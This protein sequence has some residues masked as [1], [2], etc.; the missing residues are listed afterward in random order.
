MAPGL[1]TDG[2]L[3]GITSTIVQ[4]NGGIL[5]EL[6]VDPTNDPMDLVN[7]WVSSYSLNCSVMHDKDGMTRPALATGNQDRE[8][9]FIVDLSTME[10]VW[11]EHGSHAS[12]SP[13][14]SYAAVLGM[15]E[16]CSAAYL[17]CP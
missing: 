4:Q 6:M 1:G 12:G 15:V 7:R 14:E 3:T 5:I 13:V 9:A 8:W 10:I 16:I 2:N 17:N 11:A